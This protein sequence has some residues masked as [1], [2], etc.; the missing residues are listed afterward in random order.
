[1]HA[2]HALGH[3]PGRRHG[4]IADLA[5]HYAIRLRGGTAFGVS[6][7][8]GAVHVSPTPMERPDWH[9][10]DRTRDLPPHRAGRRNPWRAIGQ[11]QVLAWGRKPWLAPR[12]PTL[13]TAP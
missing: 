11:G 9:H 3:A 1:M 13:F 2:V 8:D 12:F 6:L 4:A 10:P 5:V 7:G